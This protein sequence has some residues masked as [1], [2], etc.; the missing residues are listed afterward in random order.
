[1][2]SLPPLAHPQRSDMRDPGEVQD[3]ALR[4]I[5]SSGTERKVAT[6]LFVDVKGSMGLSGAIELEDWWS[7][8]AGLF[9]LMC[10]SV[11][12]FRGWVVNF[13]GDGVVAV[14]EPLAAAGQHARRACEAA[15]WLRD[16][17]RQ[18][19][20]EVRREHGLDLSIRLGLN[21][22]EVLTGT[23]GERYSQYYTA[24]GYTVALARRMETLALPGRIYLTEHTAAL[25]GATVRLRDLGAFEVKGAQF[26]LGVFELL[27]ADGD[28]ASDFSGRGH[29]HLAF[30]TRAQE[31]QVTNPIPGSTKRKEWR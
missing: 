19:A 13:T 2:T 26:P 15:L 29:R 10:E 20:V 24:A 9:E 16:A 7:V 17:M 11:H 30:S 22:G 3:P 25:L 12:R 31:P 14:F 28:S 23:I 8:I 27:E 6:V 18:P 21:S 4:L 5:S 1:M